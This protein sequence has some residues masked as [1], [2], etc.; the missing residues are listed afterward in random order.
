MPGCD[1][2]RS[3]QKLPTASYELHVAAQR[4]LGHVNS[5]AFW[6]LL[7]LHWRP[8]TRSSCLERIG[9]PRS[10]LLFLQC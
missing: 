8:H 6:P 9:C 7:Q 5:A 1:R 4:D 2:V 10:A 3:R